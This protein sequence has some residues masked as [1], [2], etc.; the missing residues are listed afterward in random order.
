MSIRGTE[1]RG[2]RGL[3]AQ[4]MRSCPH[5]HH[6]EQL[7]SSYPCLKG[8]NQKRVRD[9]QDAKIPRKKTY[10]GQVECKRISMPGVAQKGDL[11]M[12]IRRRER[13]RGMGVD[14]RLEGKY[15]E[16]GRKG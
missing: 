11:G 3:P 10:N 1:R 7:L 9:G 14:R 4:P 13:K 16:N 8:E 12:R 15:K 6:P 5:H 2:R